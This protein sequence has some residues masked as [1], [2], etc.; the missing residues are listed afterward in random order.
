MTS[1]PECNNKGQFGNCRH[2]RVREILAQ[3]G[4]VIGYEK[5]GVL[6]N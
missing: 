5:L 3:W 6:I 4:T 1:L 2:D